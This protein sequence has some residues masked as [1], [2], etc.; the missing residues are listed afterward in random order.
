M[1]SWYFGVSGSIPLIVSQHSISP[2]FFFP[3]LPGKG[4]SFSII[5]MQMSDKIMPLFGFAG[6]LLERRNEL[7]ST[8]KDLFCFVFCLIY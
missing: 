4:S 6:F 2:L 1:S 8:L 5:G 3:T 7:S